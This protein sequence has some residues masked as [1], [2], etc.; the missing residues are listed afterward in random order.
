MKLLEI[1]KLPHLACY[2]TTIFHK[3]Y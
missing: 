3:L 1:C 2:T